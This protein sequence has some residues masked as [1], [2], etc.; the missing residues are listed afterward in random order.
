M[1]QIGFISRRQASE[2]EDPRVGGRAE[3]DEADRTVGRDLTP[4][5]ARVED[6]FG[7]RV[8]YQNGLYSPRKPR[9]I[10][11]HRFA[12]LL[13]FL[14]LLFEHRYESRG[15]FRRQTL[16]SRGA[17]RDDPQHPVEFEVDALPLF[18]RYRSQ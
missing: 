7:A 17:F 9:A 3:S 11:G 12:P 16:I 1:K 15:F 18:E 14:T 4:L 8:G 13:K 6:S 5:H 2:V 10:P